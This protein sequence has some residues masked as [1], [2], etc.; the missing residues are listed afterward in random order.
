M[1]GFKGAKGVIWA[2][3]KEAEVGVWVQQGGARDPAQRERVMEARDACHS[4]ETWARGAERAR[5]RP[6]ILRA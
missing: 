3:A 6:A 1:L 4:L 5:E 2:I